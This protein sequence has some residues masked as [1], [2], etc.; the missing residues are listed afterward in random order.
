MGSCFRSRHMSL[1]PL[2][3][4]QCIQSRLCF[5]F[6]HNSASSQLHARQQQPESCDQTASP[7]GDGSSSSALQSDIL[8]C[9]TKQV[10]EFKYRRLDTISSDIP[11]LSGRYMAGQFKQVRGFASANSSD[12]PREA[13]EYD[14]VIVGGGPAGLGAAIRLKQ[15]C[16]EKGT[17]LSVCVVEKAAEIGQ[18]SFYVCF[19]L[20][21]NIEWGGIGSLPFHE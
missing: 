17:D 3:R 6:I 16:Q 18:T 10:R 21:M 1:S 20:L 14:V 5:S 11:A 19:E 9:Q 2:S 4:F 7:L 15:L 13:M 12:E 8:F